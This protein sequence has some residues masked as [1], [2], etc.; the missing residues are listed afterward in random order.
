[1][2]QGNCNSIPAMYTCFKQYFD[3]RVG[4]SFSL[5]HDNGFPTSTE[6]IRLLKSSLLCLEDKEMCKA[7]ASGRYCLSAEDF[8]GKL[9]VVLEDTKTCNA[10]TR[11]RYCSSMEDCY[12]FLSEPMEVPSTIRPIMVNT[13]NAVK[14][15]PADSN[16][17]RN[18]VASVTALSFALSA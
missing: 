7:G 1:M 8:A 3:I 9:T 16:G 15:Y 18:D 13:D 14:T 11:G 17:P 10:D 5:I 4:P 6:E 2:L 12:C